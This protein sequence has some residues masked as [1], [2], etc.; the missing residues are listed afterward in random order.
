MRTIDHFIGGGSYQAGE[1]QAE[2]FNPS[3]VQV[4]A[5]VRL[6]TA[7]DLQKAIDAAKAAQPQ[8]PGQIARQRWMRSSV[9]NTRSSCSGWLTAQSFC[10]A[11]RMRAPLAPPRLSPPRK[12]EAEAQAVPTSSATLRPESSTLAFRA[13]ASVASIS[14]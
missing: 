14:G 5:T 10:G 9:F 12:V 2:V 3:E 13:A 8:L 7:T 6:G 11:K 4:Q 1:R